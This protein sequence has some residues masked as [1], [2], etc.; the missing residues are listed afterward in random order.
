MTEGERDVMAESQ[1]TGA[2]GHDK[3]LYADG[4][5]IL[6]SAAEAAELMLRKI[7]TESAKYNMRLNQ[8]K[9]VL[10]RMNS[11]HNVYYTDGGA[12]PVA[13]KA[14]YLGTSMDA[15]G[16]PHVEVNARTAN[17]RTVLSKLDICWKRAPV[18]ITW[19]FRV[20]DAAIASELLYGLESASLTQA[21]RARLDA[22]QVSALRK[23]LRVPHPYYPGV[24][25]NR[26]MV[27]ANQRIR[28]AGGETMV[29]MSTRLKDRQIKFLGHLIRASDEDLT[30]TCTLTAQ[31]SRVCTGWK[32]AGRPRLKW[33]DT[34]MN[35]AIEMLQERGIIIGDWE[36]HIRRGEVVSLVMAIAESRSVNDARGRLLT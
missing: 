2:E 7:Q 9:C 19:K 18:S 20:H 6:A 17:T 34:I 11:I 22:F 3:L 5:L 28:L 26:V 29:L 30:K 4:T 1:P 21:E 27:V 35:L 16:N 13:S 36:A 31:G 24:S 12:M 14:P 25:N 15:R 23:I 33:Y 8:R 32:R 10:L